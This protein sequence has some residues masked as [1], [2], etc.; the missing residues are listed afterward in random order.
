M[1][2]FGSSAEVVI[3]AVAILL[4]AALGLFIAA[5]LGD[6][7][8]GTS[9]SATGDESERLEHER[10]LAV[11]GL[12]ELEFDQAMGKLE[13]GDY[14]ELR[15]TLERRAL[16]A[17][18]AR[19]NSARHLARERAVTAAVSSPPIV[20][21]GVNLCPQCR[22]SVGSEYRFCANCGTALPVAGVQS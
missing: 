3:W 16:A 17:M 9:A 4:I 10:T 2:K 19:E 6:Q 14:C 12:R 20:P 1:T 15:E 8:F 21:P 5:P 18:S 13:N 7:V 22:T 11:Q